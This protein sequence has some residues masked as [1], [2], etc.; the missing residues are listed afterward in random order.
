MLV[1]WRKTLPLR[2][3]GKNWYNFHKNSVLLQFAIVRLSKWLPHRRLGFKM[4]N[5]TN[6]TG[7]QSHRDAITF[8][9]LQSIIFSHSQVATAELQRSGKSKT[10][11]SFGVLSVVFL[12][13]QQNPDANKWRCCQVSGLGRP[14]NTLYPYYNPHLVGD[15]QTSDPFKCKLITISAIDVLHFD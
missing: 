10:Q 13:Q 9:P 15:Y 14:W 5:L 11:F 8:S 6:L 2:K 3:E 4:R 7:S 12:F 1:N